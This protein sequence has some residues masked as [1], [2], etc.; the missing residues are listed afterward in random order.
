[1]KTK[2][3]TNEDAL[4]GR[5]WVLVDAE[6]QVVGR[7]ASRIAAILRGKENVRFTPHNDCG[8]FVV[9]INAEKIR[10]TGNK[11]ETKVYRHHTLFPGGLREETAQDLLKRKPTEILFEAVSGMMPKSAQG[12]R[13]LKK[14][15]VFVGPEHPHSAQQPKALSV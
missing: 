5:N 9:V 13:Q 6:N 11:M 3:E 14:L 10:F 4:E 15:K 8:D 2:F 12:R 1:M 7:I